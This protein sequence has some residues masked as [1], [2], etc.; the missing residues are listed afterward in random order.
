MSAKLLARAKEIRDDGSIVEIVI[1]ELPEPLPPSPHRY[2]YRLY[3]GAAGVSRVRYDNERGKGDH[4]HVGDQEHGYSF[5][6]VE[7]LLADFQS[8]VEH[9]EQP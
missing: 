2:K 3:Y 4:R 6:S 9:W 5:T 8:D 1:W 7:Q